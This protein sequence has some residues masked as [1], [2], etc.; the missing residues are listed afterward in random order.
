[1]HRDRLIKI[2][3]HLRNNVVEDQFDLSTWVGTNE[4]PWDGLEDL[5]YGPFCNT[6]AC[7]MGHAATIPEFKKL[8]LTL[9]RHPMNPMVGIIKFEEYVYAEAVSKFLDI[10]I[11]EVDYLFMADHYRNDE[12]DFTNITKEEV[13][14]RIESFLN[15]S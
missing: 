5:T 12:D 11:N 3:N 10:S 1:M 8:G 6:V 15:E 4:K 9:V 7:A 14:S 2:M 13:A